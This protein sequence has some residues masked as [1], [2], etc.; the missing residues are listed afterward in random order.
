M[1]ISFLGLVNTILLM[2]KQASLTGF[3]SVA[4]GDD[5]YNVQQSVNQTINDLSNILRIKSRMTTFS[6]NTVASQRLYSISKRVI[7]PLISL[8]NTNTDVKMKHLMT[9]EFEYLCPDDTDSGDPEFYY[10][11]NFAGV[12]AQPA[13]T[14]EQISFVSS[15]TADISILVIQ[16]FDDSNNYVAEEVTLQ[17]TTTVTTTATF[18]RISSINKALTTGKITVTNSGGT[19]TIL[20]LNPKERTRN[21]AVIGLHPIPSSVISIT[22]RG[23]SY[24]PELINELD[25]PSG[26]PP[27]GLNA[28]V[29]GSYARYMRYYS[30]ISAEFEKISVGAAFEAYYDEVKK[31]IAADNS[32][33]DLYLRMRSSKESFRYLPSSR[34][35]D[36]ETY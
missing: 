27:E 13:S 5:A 1:D 3:S 15:S 25:I 24:M 2:N 9:Q 17:G 8:V 29:L 16:G 4:I 28:L 19:T 20:T 22:G 10:I 18:M 34:I 14:G 32:N 36:R 30:R 35:L 7:Y 31:V 26:L 11:D 33:P 6:F 23:Y 21:L 12:Q